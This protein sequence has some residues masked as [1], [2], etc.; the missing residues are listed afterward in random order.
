MH[1]ERFF[2][3][4]RMTWWRDVQND[5]YRVFAFNVV[6][7]SETKDLKTCVPLDVYADR[8]ILHYVQNDKEK[9]LNSQKNIDP[10][11]PTPVVILSETKDLKACEL[12]EVCAD[13]E[14]L[15][16]VQNELC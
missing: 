12:L 9:H 3:T 2:T 7:L 5:A 1:T 13:R 15:H 11:E 10:T 16:Y 8:E 14:I 4:F 6:I